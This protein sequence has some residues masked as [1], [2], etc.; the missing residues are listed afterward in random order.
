MPGVFGD[1]HPEF[2]SRLIR[3]PFEDYWPKPGRKFDLVVALFGVPSHIGDTDLLSGKVQWLLNP[4][5]TA[6]LMYNGRKPE[7]M[8]L[9]PQSG[10]EGARL[11]R[12]AGQ[13]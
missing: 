4:G 5:G 13:R 11:G 3:T 6:V 9:L 12:R 7:D 2:R 1:K 8:G 10:S